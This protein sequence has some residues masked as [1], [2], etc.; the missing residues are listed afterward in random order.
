MEIRFQ[1]EL[2]PFLY[3]GKMAFHGAKCSAVTIGLISLQKVGFST[4]LLNFSSSEGCSN[5]N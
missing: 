2:P 5:C 3:K 1:R 4:R